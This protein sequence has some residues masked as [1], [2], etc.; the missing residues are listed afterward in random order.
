MD[1]PATNN[2]GR[3]GSRFA[4]PVFLW[5]VTGAATQIIVDWIFKHPERFHV[6]RWLALV[7]ILPM[8]CFVVAMVRAVRKMDE[9]QRRI[10][11]ESVAVSF[12]LTVVLTLVFAGLDSTGIY[13]ASYDDVA[14][15][16]MAFWA[17]AYIFS[18]WRYR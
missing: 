17:C 2:T 14:T 11:F 15:P 1:T 7:P 6:S 12:L 16:M 8:M 9:L 18:S 4:R 5:A 13:R 10:C 3:C